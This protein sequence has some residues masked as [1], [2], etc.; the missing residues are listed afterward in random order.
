MWV[1][2]RSYRV[3]GAGPRAFRG[4]M[5]ASGGVLSE[6]YGHGGPGVCLGDGQRMPIRGIW[7]WRAWSLPGRWPDGGLFEGNGHGWPGICLGDGQTE[8]DGVS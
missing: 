3:Q 8:V 6:A 7:A 5:V 4:F 2:R 1:I